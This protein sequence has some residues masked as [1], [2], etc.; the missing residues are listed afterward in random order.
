MPGA[1]S[2]SRT[3]TR[4]KA[5]TVDSALRRLLYRSTT[6]I[7]HS[8]REYVCD[9]RVQVPSKCQHEH[10][11]L[12]YE[13]VR[14]MGRDGTGPDTYNICAGQPSGRE[15]KV[16]KLRPP[17]KVAPRREELRRGLRRVLVVC[18][19]PLLSQVEFCACFFSLLFKR[20]YCTFYGLFALLSGPCSPLFSL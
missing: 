15:E 14:T 18:A 5:N 1:P 9:F 11:F 19:V 16:R 6:R 7:L 20:P 2:P 8:T 4:N 10:K 17:E 12:D 13:S 3:G